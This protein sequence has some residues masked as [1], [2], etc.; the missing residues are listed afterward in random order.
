MS[1]LLNP[2]IKQ[3]ERDI[4]VY[5]KTGYKRE[6]LLQ[7]DLARTPYTNI[8]TFSWE[9]D[10]DSMFDIYKKYG[11]L[12]IE[13]SLTQRRGDRRWET[14]ILLTPNPKKNFINRDIFDRTYN[15]QAITISPVIDYVKIRDRVK[16]AY[17]VFVRRV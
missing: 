13:I 6:V 17:S 9:I 7:S 4:Q 1:A 5:K 10:T 12:H 8:V 11:P 2:I 3:V 16:K 15:S 14:Q